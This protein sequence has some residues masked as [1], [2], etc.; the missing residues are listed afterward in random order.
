MSALLNEAV[1]FLEVASFGSKYTGQAGRSTTRCQLI[2]AQISVVLR[3]NPCTRAVYT[4]AGPHYPCS[5]AV[6]CLPSLTTSNTRPACYLLDDAPRRVMTS[7][8][9]DV[10]DYVTTRL[11]TA[12]TPSDD[13]VNSAT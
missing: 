8:D 1:N 3:L 13:C 2:S 6:E 11:L 10:T 7:R 12:Y 4:G 5:R 9:S